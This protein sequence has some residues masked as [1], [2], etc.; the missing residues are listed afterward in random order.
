VGEDWRASATIN[1]DEHALRL[2]EA[3]REWRVEH[4]VRDRLGERVAVSVGDGRVFLYAGTREA[5]REAVRVASDVLA[6]HEIEADFTVA[7]W[8]PVAEEWEPADVPLPRSDSE[9]AAEHERL[10]Q[11]DTEESQATGVA[12]WEVRVEL[13]SHRDAVA[14]AERLEADS[15]AVV[16]RWTFLLVGANS[17]DEAK[18]LAGTIES[19]APPGALIEVEPSGA[20]PLTPFAVFGGLGG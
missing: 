17:E 4:D 5:V 12:Q 7:R 16:R 20:T 9:R 10:E 15:Y 13:G 8:H 14:L 3:L 6:E 1:E 11:R 18:E 2:L 19:F